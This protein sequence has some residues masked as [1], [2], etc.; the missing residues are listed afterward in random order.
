MWYV[1]NLQW[2]QNFIFRN[3]KYFPQFIDKF[4]QFEVM[5][6]LIHYV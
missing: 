6:Y 1:Q 3:E 2:A 4:L 5:E